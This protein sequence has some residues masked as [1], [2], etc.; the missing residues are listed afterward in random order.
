M[1]LFLAC[2]ILLRE[3]QEPPGQ[4]SSSKG[5]PSPNAA[6]NPQVSR[7]GGLPVNEGSSPSPALVT[8]LRPRHRQGDRAEG[9][10]TPARTCTGPRATRLPRGSPREA[11]LGQPGRL[12]GAPG[13]GTCV[14]QPHAD[15][16]TEPLP[17]PARDTTPHG[18]NSLCPPNSMEGAL[19]LGTVP[20][21]TTPSES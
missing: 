3:C 20:L 8:S 2:P 11:R 5:G 4:T 1:L 16:S 21:L 14:S 12:H 17:W 18:G 9:R 19:S 6:Q 15:L 13:R 10:H 7:P